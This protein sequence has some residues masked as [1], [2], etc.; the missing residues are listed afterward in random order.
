MNRSNHHPLK[1]VKKF[2]DS[3]CSERKK[4]EIRLNDRDFQTGDTMMFHEINDDGH[5]TGRYSQTFVITHVFSYFALKE[6]YVCLS[7][8]PFQHDPS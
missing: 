4:A 5:E 6:D 1:L 3:V 8:E 2:F 7:I